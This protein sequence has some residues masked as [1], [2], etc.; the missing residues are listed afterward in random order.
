VGRARTPR[1]APGGGAALGWVRGREALRR[2]RS[3]HRGSAS[4]AVFIPRRRGSFVAARLRRE[5]VAH[6]LIFGDRALRASVTELSEPLAGRHIAH[7]GPHD[8]HYSRN[9]IM[10]NALSMSGA[11]VTQIADG[12]TS[13]GAHRDFSA[14]WPT[15]TSTR[16]S[17]DFRPTPTCRS[18]GQWDGRREVPS[19]STYSSRSGRM[20][21]LIASRPLGGAFAPLNIACTTASRAGSPT[22]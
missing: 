3:S 7:F 2:Q 20:R 10:A 13:C 21:S 1:P 22:S 14:G 9:R 4:S 16:S 11:D 17:L 18:P 12:R 19:S 8:P 15:K 5:P 6:V